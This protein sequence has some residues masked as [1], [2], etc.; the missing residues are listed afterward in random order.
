MRKF[1]AAIPKERQQ[2]HPVLFAA[3]L[4]FELGNIH[5]F[6][7]GNGR[8]ARLLL[9]LA[10][11]QAGYPLAVIPPVRRAEYIQSLE[12][13]SLGRGTEPYLNLMLDVVHSSTHDYRRLLKA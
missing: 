1:A 13:A 12:A 6:V 10:L 4:H 8:A 7:D 5:P 9:N 11:L 2:Q 3:W